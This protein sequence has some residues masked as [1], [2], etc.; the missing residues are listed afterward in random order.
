MPHIPRVQRI[1]AKS[2][3]AGFIG[4]WKEAIPLARWWRLTRQSGGPVVEQA[5][6]LLD[7]GL[8]LC[9]P[10]KCASA[11]ATARRPKDFG[12][13]SDLVMA[14]LEFHS[15]AIGQLV[16][17]C[18]LNRLAHRIGYDVITWKTE[19]SGDRN[20]GVLIATEDGI[21]R[22]KGNYSYSYR[23]ET[24]AFIDAV[25]SGKPAGILSDFRDA[26][27]TLA[28]AET[29]GK[30]AKTGQTLAVPKVE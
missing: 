21:E 9:G 22:L 6:H 1:L 26:M 20:G 23:S 25:R 3:P 29:I 24:N 2:K 30:A 19:I 18:L 4:V 7:L 5:S 17:T 27:E 10:V 8:F 16:H 11:M 12:D 14:T 13:I 15:G 28:L